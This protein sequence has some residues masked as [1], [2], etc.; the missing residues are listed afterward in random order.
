MYEE[1]IDQRKDETKIVCLRGF[2][3]IQL[4]L[5]FHGSLAIGSRAI[6]TFFYIFVVLYVYGAG[7]ARAVGR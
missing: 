5:Q 4:D 2:D 7:L 1:R 3:L 6:A